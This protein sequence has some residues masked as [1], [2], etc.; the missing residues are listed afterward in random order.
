[1]S[2]AAWVY[3][4]VLDRFREVV[5]RA[6]EP[7]H[8]V[9][10]E[11]AWPEGSAALLA[12]HL[13]DSHTGPGTAI[14]RVERREVVRAALEKLDP[15]DREILALRYFDGL[16]F[17]QIGAI[18]GPKANTANS[19]ALRAAVKLKQ[20]IPRAFRPLGGSQS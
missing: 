17:T 7:E 8:N 3:G 15:V 13:V 2:L 9:A 6:L 18:L 11:V 14:S 1:L 20:L 10:R 19:K 16:N 5:R 4:Q 12:E